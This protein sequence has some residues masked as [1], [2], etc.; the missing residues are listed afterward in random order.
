M[1][2]RLIMFITNEE[3]IQIAHIILKS[4][5]KK[6]ETI[7]NVTQQICLMPCSIRLDAEFIYNE[8]LYIYRS[9]IRQEYTNIIC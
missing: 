9:A 2:E 7:H 1:L 8:L 4:C 5:N 3:A 6:P